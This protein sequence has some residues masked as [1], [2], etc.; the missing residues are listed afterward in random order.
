MSRRFGF[1]KSD[2]E[3][4]ITHFNLKRTKKHIKNFA[5]ITYNLFDIYRIKN[6]FY[7]FI[8]LKGKT[9]RSM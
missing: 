8:I 5:E 4:K 9:G 3:Q 7:I 6:I 1:I 2:S